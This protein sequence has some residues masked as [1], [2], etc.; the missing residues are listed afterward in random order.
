VRGR[1]HRSSAAQLE[2]AARRGPDGSRAWTKP[3]QEEAALV[4]RDA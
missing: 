4:S 2:E 3:P 1:R